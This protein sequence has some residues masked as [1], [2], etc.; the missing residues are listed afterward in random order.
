MFLIT[1]Q[2]AALE[3]FRHNNRH[4]T[5]AMD[6]GFEANYLLETLLLQNDG[7]IRANWAHGCQ[8]LEEVF[9]IEWLFITPVEVN[10]ERQGFS[11]Y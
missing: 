7:R 9:V 8:T 1:V 6:E 5:K 4:V 3:L 2:T 10:V 11:D